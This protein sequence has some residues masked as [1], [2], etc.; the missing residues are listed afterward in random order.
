[1][2]GTPAP[3]AM[4]FDVDGVIAETPHEESWRRALETLCVRPD[5]SEAVAASHWSPGGFT[6]DIYLDI[7]AG[8]ERREGA[9]EVLGRFGIADPD[10]SRLGVLFDEKQRIFLEMI[11][12]GEVRIYDD[13]IDLARRAQDAGWKLAVASSS[14]NATSILEVLGL[15]PL[16][17][18]DVCGR[19]V[20]GKPAPD[21]FLAAAEELGVRRGSCCVVE[22]ATSGVRAAHRGGFMCLA[23]ARYDD[24]GDLWAAGANLVTDSLAD[25]TIEEIDLIVKELKH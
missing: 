6:R 10:G 1:L 12:Q 3:R 8:R 24:M 2:T 25:V 17:D 11:D 19:D 21:L 4:I 5:W 9:K 15:M 7:C 20:P 22:D 18:A 14:R 16:F 13:A 23:V